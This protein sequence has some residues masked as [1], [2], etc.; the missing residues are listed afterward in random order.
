MYSFF[1]KH[2]CI[3]IFR[4]G[5]VNGGLPT[6][7]LE[8]VPAVKFDVNSVSVSTHVLRTKKKKE[9]KVCS[10]VCNKLNMYK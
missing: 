7:L 2:P 6:W 8:L 5:D 10:L 3:D 4:Q 1:S 9:K